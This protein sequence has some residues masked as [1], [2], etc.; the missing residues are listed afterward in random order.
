MTGRCM[1]HII[2]LIVNRVLDKIKTKDKED[3][4]KY[5]AYQNS[6]LEIIKNEKFSYVLQS[7]YSIN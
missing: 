6:V 1:G 7:F 4:A 5:S 2:Q 3:N